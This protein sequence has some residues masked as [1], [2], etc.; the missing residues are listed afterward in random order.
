MKME[1]PWRLAGL[2]L[3]WLCTS[4]FGTSPAVAETERR[5]PTPDEYIEQRCTFCHSRILTL[6]LLKRRVEI[7]GLAEMD[8]F[9][10][11]H[12]MPDAGARDVLLRYLE[13]IG[14]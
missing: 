14:Q 8:G 10:A 11:G 1:R 7:R 4:M 13:R 5:Q 12:H 2:I 3:L 6:V 9:L